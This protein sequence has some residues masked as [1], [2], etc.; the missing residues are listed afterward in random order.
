MKHTSLLLSLFA[1]TCAAA[2][3]QTPKYQAIYIPPLLTSPGGN[4]LAV[5]E[6]QPG[7]FYV[8]AARQT[9]TFGAVILS[10]TGGGTAKPLSEFPPS[11]N[12]GPPVQAANGVLCAPAVLPTG[13][14]GLYSVRASGGQPKEYPYPGAWGFVSPL[15]VAPNAMYGTAGMDQS[16]SE[17][18]GLS[19]VSET[20]AITMLGQIPTGGGFPNFQNY[21][22]YGPDGNFYGVGNQ[23][24]HGISPGLIYRFTPTGTYSQLLTFPGFP[25]G[26]ASLPLIAGSD[27]NLYGSFNN[28]GENGAGEIYQATLAGKFTA[29]ASFPATGM[30]DPRSLLQAADGNIYGTTNFNQ[31]FRYNLATHALTLAYQLNPNSVQGK[32][33]CQL[34]E[35]MDGKLYGVTPNG[36]PTGL[37]IVFSLDLGLPKPLPQVSGIFPSSGPVGKQVILWGN[38][39]LGA[40]SVTFNGTPAVKPVS[41]SVQSIL[42]TVPTGAT[43]GPVTVTTA[44]G[45]FTTTQIFTVQ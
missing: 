44:N 24:E 30:S 19:E 39:L 21:P 17:A 15:I 35:G 26:G 38:Y 28:L 1:C 23:Q 36:G 29:V 20:G 22:I 7:L 40:T 12:V 43:T 9:N 32:C 27:G 42:V 4:P 34:I 45:S 37:G 14:S 8:L 6:V 10:T 5:L 31:I 41:T 18:F 25:R 13:S 3:A 33:E 16:S 11:T 2:A